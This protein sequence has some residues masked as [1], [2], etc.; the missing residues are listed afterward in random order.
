MSAVELKKI[1]LTDDNLPK[2]FAIVVGDR[3]TSKAVQHILFDMGVSWNSGYA[4]P[5]YLDAEVLFVTERVHHGYQFSYGDLSYYK[6]EWEGK[7]PTIQ[8]EKEVITNYSL[9]LE[10]RQVVI[11]GKAYDEGKVLEALRDMGVEPL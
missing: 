4:R 2:K 3:E 11:D 5:N 9:M 6:R 10:S 8:V 1:P 7:Y